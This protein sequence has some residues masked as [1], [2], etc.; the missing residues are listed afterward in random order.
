MCAPVSS[1]VQQGWIT[2]LVECAEASWG[3]STRQEKGWQQAT[4][5][6]SEKQTLFSR[7]QRMLN[8]NQSSQSSPAEGLPRVSEDQADLRK[9]RND[10]AKGCWLSADWACSIQ[11]VQLPPTC[12][13]SSRGAAE[14]SFLG[15][16]IQSLWTDHRQGD[17]GGASCVLLT[18]SDL[19]HTQSAQACQRGAD[20]MCRCGAVLLNICSDSGTAWECPAPLLSRAGS[21]WALPAV[22]GVSAS[23]PWCILTPASL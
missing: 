16:G 4:C 2:L 22:R 8:K 15:R 6:E 23:R 9:C 19:C 11:P 20:L 13:Q 18:D 10:E 14:L 12:S 21:C 7:N 17:A 1:F 3:K 5:K